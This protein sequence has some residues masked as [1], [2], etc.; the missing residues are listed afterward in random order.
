M[1]RLQLSDRLQLIADMVP[2]CEVMAD[3]GTDHGYLPI[4]LSQMGRVHKAY[5]MDINKGPLTRAEENIDRYQVKAQVQTR[6]SDGLEHLPQDTQVLVIAGMGGMLM[7]EIL[8][9]GRRCLEGLDT[10]ILSPHLD[11]ATLRRKV[12][13]LNWCIREER[14]MVDKD[15]FYTVMRCEKGQESYTA[16]AYR[17]GNRKLL[18]DDPY[19]HPYLKHHLKKLQTIKEQLEKQPTAKAENR[20]KEIAIGIEEIKAVMNSE[21]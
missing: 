9:N 13:A 21:T 19:W 6:L 4:A 2:P 17:Y 3:V 7:A 1:E 5:A 18:Q 15:K 12:H 10:M 20:L 14:M 11:A 8:E 16:T